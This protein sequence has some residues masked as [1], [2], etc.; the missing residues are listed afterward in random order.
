MEG[1]SIMTSG[2]N[3]NHSLSKAI[4]IDLDDI[5][6]GVKCQK[7]GKPCEGG[8]HFNHRICFWEAM[9]GNRFD[10]DPFY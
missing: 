2:K 4:A 7:K 6:Q 1:E 5:A 10:H 9:E 3:E 8:T